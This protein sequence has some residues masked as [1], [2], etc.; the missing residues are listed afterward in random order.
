VIIAFHVVELVLLIAIGTVLVSVVPRLIANRV[1]DGIGIRDEVP[2][3]R[4]PVVGG[5][6][7]Q[8]PPELPAPEE[9][10]V[11]EPLQGSVAARLRRRR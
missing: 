6:T 3:A 4:L 9:K 8:P 1:L 10:A 5:F 11:K 2:A 7:G